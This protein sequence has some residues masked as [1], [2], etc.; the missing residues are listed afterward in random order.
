[1]TF[2]KM[3]GEGDIISQFRPDSK[4]EVSTDRDDVVS[5]LMANSDGTQDGIIDALYNKMAHADAGDELPS[6]QFKRRGED[7]NDIFYMFS[8][9]HGLENLALVDDKDVEGI[10][11]PIALQKLVNSVDREKE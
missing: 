10:D 3:T 11:D 1:M 7:V 4:K 2:E 8:R 9:I 5:Y 6:L